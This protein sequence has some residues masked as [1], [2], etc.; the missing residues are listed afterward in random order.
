MALCCGGSNRCGHRAP[1]QPTTT[2]TFKAD[3]A[4]QNHG[5]HDATNPGRSTVQI[6]GVY[7]VEKGKPMADPV[8]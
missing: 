8:P 4:M 6:L 5:I 3:N 1:T 7:I 2:K